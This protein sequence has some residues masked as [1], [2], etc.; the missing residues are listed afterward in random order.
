MPVLVAFLTNVGAGF[1]SLGYIVVYQ[2]IENYILSPR[3]TAKTMDLHPAVAFAAVLIGGAL[4]GVLFAFLSLP[5]AGVL[6]AALK[7]YSKPYE[8]VDDGRIR[9]TEPAK[10]PKPGL[11]ERLRKKPDGG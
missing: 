6:Q 3:L 11:K 2:Q 10:A 5:V 9:E 1:W 8:V 7:E 4:G